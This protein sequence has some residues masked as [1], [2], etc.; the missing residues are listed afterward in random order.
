M[1]G[2]EVKYD[3]GPVTDVSTTE[4]LHMLTMFLT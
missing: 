4:Y 2:L 1:S 3:T